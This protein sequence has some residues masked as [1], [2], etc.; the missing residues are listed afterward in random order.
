LEIKDVFSGKFVSGL[1]QVPHITLEEEREKIGIDIVNYKNILFFISHICNSFLNVIE[2]RGWERPVHFFNRSIESHP[3]LD[4]N[5]L[6][7]VLSRPVKKTGFDFYYNLYKRAY[8][9]F[10]SFP[11]VS[12][13]KE[14]YEVERHA[15]IHQNKITIAYIC[16]I[17]DKQKGDLKNFYKD[18]RS[19]AIKCPKQFIIFEKW[20]QLYEKY[21]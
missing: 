1:R 16:H 9:E 12:A 18:P 13:P 2:G 11:F 15:G 21:L 20:R 6:T 7:T 8:P 10:L 14:R 4:V 17:L 3:F 5:F 19:V